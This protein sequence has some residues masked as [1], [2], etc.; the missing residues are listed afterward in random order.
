MRRSRP[1]APPPTRVPRGSWLLGGAA[2]LLAAAAGVAVSEAGAALLSG[3]TSP[4][5]SVGNRAVDAT[6][7]PLKELAIETFGAR[8]KPVL[9]TGVVLTVAVLAVLAGAAGVRRP[10]LALGGF[11][12]LGAVA[13]A[14]V[15]T[16]R[17]ATAGP[18]L[19]LLPVLGLVGV[20]VGALHLLLRALRTA[21]APTRQR[22]GTGRAPTTGEGPAA[23]DRR[24]FLLTAGAVGALA[25][26]GGLVRRAFGGSAA[27]LQRA[28][29]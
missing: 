5:L 28:D 21:P 6:P 10:R 14:V 19:R 12:L 1:T 2:G 29:I 24:G 13:A 16:D 23:F 8:D 7:R 20:S 9:I 4:L 18:A 26:A 25:A 17:A 22:A 15:V 11:L 27:A 3:V